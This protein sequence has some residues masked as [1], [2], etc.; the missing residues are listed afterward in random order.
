MATLTPRQKL[1]AAMTRVTDSEKGWAPYFGCALLGLIRREM[2]ATMI[3]LMEALG[4]PCTLAVTQDGVLYWASEFVEKQTVD[5]LAWILMHEVMHLLLRH[6]DRAAAIG[7]LPE[8]SPEMIA[9]STIANYAQDACIN[10][11]LDKFQRGPEDCIRPASL[12]QS[13]GLIFEERYRLLLK[14][15]EKAG[16]GSGKDK[17]PQGAGKGWCGG[18]AG[19]PVPGEPNGK[20]GSGKGDADDGPGR[21]PAE[22]ERMRKETAQAING[23]VA[24]KGRGTVPDSMVRWADEQLAPPKIDWRPHLAQAVRGAVASRSGAV[25]LTWNKPSRR[26]AGVGFGS[27]RPLMPSYQAPIPE[28]GFGVDSSGSMSKD[29]LTE[30]MVEAQGVLK[31]LGAPFTFAVCD[32]ALHG[33]KEVASINEAVAMLKG[34]GGTDMRP[35]F[36]GFEKRP[37][38]PQVVIIATDG[39]IGSGY[40]TE[41]PTWCKTVWLVVSGGNPQPCP[42]GETVLIDPK[43]LQEAA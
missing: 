4:K 38:R 33:I 8:A 5:V 37:K 34:G 30:V 25:D 31:A 7:I 35:L 26:Q 18:C 40:P 12:K 41:E 32:A 9:K 22:L 28:V 24:S 13:P 42:W 19:H 29:D 39:H 21:T 36:D 11:E 14:E 15:I 23:H 10:E 17:G 16:G 43:E 1:A 2:D 3:A 6:H 20:G 27:G